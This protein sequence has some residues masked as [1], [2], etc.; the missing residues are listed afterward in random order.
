MLR[1]CDVL[2][3][4]SGCGDVIEIPCAKRYTNN[5]P[6][7]VCK[8]TGLVRSNITKTSNQVAES[9]SRDVYADSFSAG[10]YTARI[11]AVIARL[12]YVAHSAAQL[13]GSRTLNILDAGAGE[14]VLIEILKSMEFQNDFY[15]IEPSARNCVHLQASGVATFEG[16]IEECSRASHQ[17][18]LDW[19]KMDWIFLTWTLVNCANVIEV[20]D[21]CKNLLAPGGRI[22][23]AEGSRVLVPFKKPLWDY[24]STQDVNLHPWHFSA[25]SLENL[26]L[27]HGM[28]SV[29]TN[30]YFDSDVL[31]KVFAVQN[32]PLEDQLVGDNY[33]EVLEFF[34]RW[35]FESKRMLNW[36]P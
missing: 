26:F 12:T 32:T 28:Q 17:G 31:M 16:T 10:K 25:R 30:R 5:Q 19:P 15:A 21:A 7:Y 8:N 20:I 4:F 9:W 18:S 14:G 24:F 23:V 35:E 29:W 6:V 27:I 36:A 11:P 1:N 3:D 13:F 34:E 33:L 2:A 22:V